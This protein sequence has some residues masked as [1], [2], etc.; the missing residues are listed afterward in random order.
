MIININDLVPTDN[1]KLYR[2]EK[3]DPTGASLSPPEYVYLKYA[4]GELSLQP[5]TINRELLLAMQG[6]QATTTVFN[7]NGS[8]TETNSKNETLQTVFN[9]NGS[10]TQTFTAGSQVITKTTTFNEDGSIS[11][12]IS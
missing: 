7:S 3:V 6:F 10:I 5:T 4:P 8:I 11:E 12:V 2:Y 1:T 9:A